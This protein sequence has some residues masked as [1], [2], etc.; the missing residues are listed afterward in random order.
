ME[1]MRREIANL[2]LDM[3][4][5]GRNLKVS[6]SL[7]LSGSVTCREVVLMHGIA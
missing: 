2:Q 1:E 4:R 6:P 5:M 3:L 7:D